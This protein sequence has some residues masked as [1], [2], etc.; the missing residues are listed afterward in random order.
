[1]IT[2]ERGDLRGLVNRFD[3]GRGIGRRRGARL[4]QRANTGDGADRLGLI[5]DKHQKIF[6][7]KGV[8]NIDLLI[9][10]CQGQLLAI[11]GFLAFEMLEV[12][13]IAGIG[14]NGKQ[15]GACDA[16]ADLKRLGSG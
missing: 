6:A 1:M 13:G 5:A 15:P 8:G 14:G 12:E 10:G 16:H 7:D 11:D 9:L 2:A 3:R 4:D